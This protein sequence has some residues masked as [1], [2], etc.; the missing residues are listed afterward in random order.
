MSIQG[1]FWNT[2]LEHGH[3]AYVEHVNDDGTFLV[4]ECNI[5]GIQDQIHWTVW[6]NQ[7]YLSFAIPPK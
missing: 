7:S 5:R 4:S 6:T 2:P 1:G 3:V